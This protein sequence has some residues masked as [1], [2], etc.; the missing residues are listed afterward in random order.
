VLILD[1]DATDAPL[2]G[3]Q[4]G[5]FFQGYYGSLL[6][7]ALLFL[8]FGAVVSATALERQGPEHGNPGGIEKNRRGDSAVDAESQDCGAGDSGMCLIFGA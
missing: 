8:R 4:E 6:P 2:H 7:A 1:F 5:R 3:L